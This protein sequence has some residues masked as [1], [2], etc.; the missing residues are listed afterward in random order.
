MKDFKDTVLIVDDEED[1]LF[2]LKLL[3]KNDFNVITSPSA[4]EAFEVVRKNNIQI[5]VTDQKMPGIGGTAL[6]RQV[7][8]F[9]P[10][11]VRILMTGYT[12]IEIAVSAI[13]EGEIYHYITKP[14][15]PEKFISAL[16]S[17]SRHYHKQEEN[18]TNYKKM[19]D[20]LNLF[21]NQKIITEIMGPGEAIKQLSEQIARVSNTNFTV[22]LTGESGTGKEVLCQIIHQLSSRNDKKMV[23][24]NCGAIPENL[25]E[26]EL[27]GY[28]K[29]AFTGANAQKIGMIE[30]AQNGTF[31][32]DEISELPYNMQSKLLRV[33]QEK[34]IRRVGGNR[35]IPI[36]VR[37]VAASNQDLEEM[38]KNKKFRADLFYRIAEYIIPIPALRERKTDIVFLAEKFIK[39]TNE[40]LYKDAYLSERA[41]EM[42]LKYQW[43]GNVRQLRNVIRKSVLLADETILPKHIHIPNFQE[44]MDN[45]IGGQESD[46]DYWV[47]QILSDGISLREVLNEN[48]QNLEKKIIRE[49]LKQMK[50]NKSKASKVLQIDYKTL[51][52]KI[53]YYSL[54]QQEKSL[55]E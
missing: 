29:G 44:N 39:E 31:F 5:V 42:L 48:I 38:V 43:P 46:M 1:I 23:T 15:D 36:D 10:R 35:D 22:L 34:R 17:A 55:S 14:W 50:G 6:L 20:A 26:S 21:S 47:R 9:N 12:E 18:E 8:E 25:L 53:K 49:V 51:Y 54:E 30:S 32:L 24:V 7:K 3:L 13:N 28:E 16:Q 45:R 11:I 4:E 27:F 33:L 2:S 19:Q 41:I 37:F 52:N 40:E